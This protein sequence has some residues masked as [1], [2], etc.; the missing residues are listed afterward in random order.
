M[1]GAGLPAPHMAL[2]QSNARSERRCAA[3]MQWQGSASIGGRRTFCHNSILCHPTEHAYA[4]GETAA[5]AAAAAALTEGDGEQHLRV[6]L[7]KE[8]IYPRAVYFPA[9]GWIGNIGSL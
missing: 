9:F 2:P 3:L 6:E 5:M 4:A 1:K 7:S 8:T